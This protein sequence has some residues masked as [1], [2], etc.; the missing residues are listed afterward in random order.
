M[1]IPKDDEIRKPALELLKNND[2][3]KLKEFEQPLSKLFNFR[4]DELSEIY[5]SG[6]G[7]VFY[8]RIVWALSNLNTAWLVQ[9]PK[10]GYYQITPQG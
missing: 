8:D 3:I 6:N 1:S 7:P 5:D 10:R 4:Q 2:V 9:R